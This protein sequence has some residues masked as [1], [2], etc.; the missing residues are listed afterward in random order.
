MNKQEVIAL[1]KELEGCWL[2]KGRPELAAN[3]KQRAD[4]LEQS[5]VTYP[6]AIEI[7][8]DRLMVMAEAQ[9]LTS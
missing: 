4:M 6:T 5:P 3:H 9:G 8:G 1:H 7:E 2:T